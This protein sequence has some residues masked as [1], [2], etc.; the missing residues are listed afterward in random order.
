MKVIAF[1]AKKS[2]WGLEFL[3]ALSSLSDSYE[4]GLQSS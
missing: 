1:E 4:P 3:I 2:A